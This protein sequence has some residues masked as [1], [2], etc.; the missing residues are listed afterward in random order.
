MPD[1]SFIEAR[2]KLERAKKFVQEFVV[3]KLSVDVDGLS[4]ESKT[5][6]AL[7]LRSYFWLCS[8]S[9]LDTEKDIQGV[10]AGARS[11]FELVVDMTLIKA[12]D[13]PRPRPPS[14]M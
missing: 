7:F 1:P 5:L 11:L 10:A 3:P 14:S 9:K 2:S 8:I 6:R 12:N 4:E 13:P